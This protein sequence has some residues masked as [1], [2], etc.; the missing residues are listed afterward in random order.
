MR[1]LPCSSACDS[2]L[3][4]G[5]PLGST[6]ERPLVTTIAPGST[7]VAV[8]FHHR[9]EF[10]DDW[11]GGILYASSANVFPTFYA[12]GPAYLSGQGYNRPV[13]ALA[14]TI[15]LFALSGIPPF[16]GF[17]AKFVVFRAAVNQGFVWLAVIGVVNSLISVFYYVRV[18]YILYMRPLPERQP[19]YRKSFAIASAAL[20]AAVLTLL[21][22]LY[23][24]FVLA[25]AQSAILGLTR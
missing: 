9:W 2:I 11:D 20:V 19:E 24:S 22:G 4:I 6:P 25:A 23:P 13:A 14:L 10:E 18:I 5:M 1:Q 3:P 17:T 15:C 8:D 12:I 21:L 16:I 7:G